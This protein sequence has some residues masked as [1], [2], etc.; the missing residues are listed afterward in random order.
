[1]RYQRELPTWVEL[2]HD[3][4]AFG[5]EL[6]LIETATEKLPFLVYVAPSG[7]VFR[8]AIYF[9]DG[10]RQVSAVVIDRILRRLHIDPEDFERQQ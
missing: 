6:K 2:I 5:V 7:L 9:E 10:N 1:M 3:L 4:R 8:T